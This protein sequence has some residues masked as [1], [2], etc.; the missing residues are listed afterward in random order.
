MKSVLIIYPVKEYVDGR[1]G[2]SFNLNMLSKYWSYVLKLPKGAFRNRFGIINKLIDEYR[3]NKFN[4]NWLLF[5]S[6]FD[7]K[8]PDISR[9]S[10]YFN[11][12]KEDKLI[13]AGITRDELNSYIY[14]NEEKI[15][16]RLDSLSELVLG[17]FHKSD[18][19]NRFN[20]KANDLGINSR[21][22]KLLTE[23]FFELILQ[24]FGYDFDFL[25]I[26]KGVLDREMHEDD[27]EE[28]KRLILGERI[29]KY[30][31]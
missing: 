19:V 28:T 3:E 10:K 16:S 22:D 11:I 31:Y 15:I 1:Y 17:G 9:K 27:P 24:S 14:P 23:D 20:L 6:C 7:K 5:S 4:V 21:I 29:Y 30:L 12:K 26:K 8:E 18:C 2:N 13:P 25:N